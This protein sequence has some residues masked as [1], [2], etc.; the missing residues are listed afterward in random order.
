MDRNYKN[1]IEAFTRIYKDGFVPDQFYKWSAISLVAAVL[2]RK[3]WIP[4]NNG[5]IYPNMYVFLVAKPGVGKSTAMDRATKL[6]NKMV[7]GHGSLVRILPNKVTE[8]K[9]LD[10]LNEQEYFMYNNKQFPH[11]SAYYVASEASACFH[12]VYGGFVQTLT[13]LYDG[14]DIKK[15]TVSRKQEVHVVNPCLNIV[16]GCT[17][18]FL[19]KLLTTEGIMGGF[20]SRITYVIQDEMM[21]RTSTWL[22]KDV[23][24]AN[25]DEVYKLMND[26]HK[27]HTMV[28]GFGADQEF[29][30]AWNTW[31]PEFDKKLQ[32]TKNEKLQALMVRKSAAMR[33][34]PMIL[35]AAESSDMMLR[36]RHWD[37]AIALMDNVESKIPFMIREGQASNTRTQTGVNSMILKLLKASNRSNM[38]EDMLV[39]AATSSGHSGILVR[40][41]L[42]DMCKD[43]SMVARKGAGIQLIGNPDEII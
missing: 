40:Q 43:G 26:L 24:K 16:A 8:P 28:G 27:I 7:E 37:E 17:F 11:T 22:G 3:V 10:I 6:L 36:K 18:D 34:L 42:L 32:T 20:A 5:N 2:E 35:S 29:A 39:A 38:S 33:K 15:A 31:F 14:N 4:W 13:A 12:D 25:E 1:F 19:G 23:K 30:D 21:E 41:T 9:L